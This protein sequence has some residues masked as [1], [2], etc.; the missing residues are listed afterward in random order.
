MVDNYIILC[1]LGHNFELSSITKNEL[2]LQNKRYNPCIIIISYDMIKKLKLWNEI[3]I[4]NGEST[5]QQTIKS[6]S[7][8]PS[9]RRVSATL[10]DHFHILTIRKIQ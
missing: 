4:S 3:D 8:M 10:L 6:V 9:L 5:T 1:S 2:N 7:V